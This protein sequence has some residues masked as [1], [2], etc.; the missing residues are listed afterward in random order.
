MQLQQ[1]KVDEIKIDRSFVAGLAAGGDAMLI[2][3]TIDLAR[4][5]GVRVV[6]EGIEDEA[7]RARLEAL[8]CEL[9]QGFH[10]SPPLDGD[11]VLAWAAVRRSAAV[12]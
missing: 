2:R 12:A 4:S 5:L 9:G 6:A 8:G 3:S 7:T 10:L 1:L 11:D